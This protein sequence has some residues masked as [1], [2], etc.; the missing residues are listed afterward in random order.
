MLSA[1][2]RL[3]HGDSVTSSSLSQGRR[4]A[5]RARVLTARRT[6]ATVPQTRS[7]STV[8]GATA[9][10]TANFF[11]EERQ[12]QRLRDLKSRLESKRVLTSIDGEGSS[13]LPPIGELKAPLL[14]PKHNAKTGWTMGPIGFGTYRISS[15]SMD[16]Q[17]ALY[18]LL[19]SIFDQLDRLANHF[20]HSQGAGIANRR[21]KRDRLQSELRQGIRVA[22]GTNSA[23]FDRRT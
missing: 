1:T 3:S 5:S 22:S 15:Q 17:N 11:S 6:T 21:Y 13:N 10:G 16:H 4:I 19:S 12:Q 9:K 18:V 7:M 14:K 8:M 23:Q 2:L 20:S